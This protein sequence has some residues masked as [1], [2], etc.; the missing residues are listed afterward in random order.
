MIKQ[1]LVI[2]SFA[3]ILNSCKDSK[4]YFTFDEVIQYKLDS[5]IDTESLFSENQKNESDSLRKAIVIGEKPNKIDDSLFVNNLKKIGFNKIKVNPFK[6]AE[7]NKLYSEK[8]SPLIKTSTT[9]EPIYRD[10]L[11]FKNTGKIIGI[12]KVCFECLR[13]E[14]IGLSGKLKAFERENDY[15]DLKNYL[16]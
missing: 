5:E 16:Q 3:I 4:N 1:I 10:I 15:K 6:Y 11:I 9:C 7:I 2:F 8:M 13:S 12:S 14:N